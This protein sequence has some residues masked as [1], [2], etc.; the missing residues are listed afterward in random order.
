MLFATPHCVCDGN[1]FQNIFTEN[2][3]FFVSKKK[4]KME[5]KIP[6]LLDSIV[7]RVHVC[8]NFGSGLQT[9]VYPCIVHTG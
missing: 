5:I 9:C 1:P 7:T 4:K 3:S 8:V 6:V 2:A